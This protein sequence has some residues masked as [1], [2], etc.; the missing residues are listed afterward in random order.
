MRIT[1]SS[2]CCTCSNTANENIYKHYQKIVIRIEAT[3]ISANEDV[4]T[5]CEIAA[6]KDYNAPYDKAYA[7]IIVAVGE[8]PLKTG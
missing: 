7:W 3:H 6:P 1:F 2:V 8:K 4:P 5:D